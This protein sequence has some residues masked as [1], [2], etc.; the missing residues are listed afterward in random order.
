MFHEGIIN[1]MLVNSIKFGKKLNDTKNMNMDL[2]LLGLCV[3][4]E[5]YN[6][7]INL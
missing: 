1:Y 3:G 4:Q 2:D 7:Y 6:T 5:D